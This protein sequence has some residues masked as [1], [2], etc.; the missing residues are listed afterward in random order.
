VVASRTQP[1]AH[2]REREI[3]DFVRAVA[4]GEQ[5]R[6]SFDDGL[7][8][9]KVLDAVERSSAAASTWTSIS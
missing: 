4:A 3:G 2:V 1:R 6:P 9:Q 5:P 8:V 7:Y